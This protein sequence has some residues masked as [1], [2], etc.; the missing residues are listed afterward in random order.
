MMLKCLCP[1]IIIMLVNIVIF[2]LDVQHRLRY[3][4]LEGL[5]VRLI[6]WVYSP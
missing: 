4:D 2:E 6:E 1:K 3:Q 5:F